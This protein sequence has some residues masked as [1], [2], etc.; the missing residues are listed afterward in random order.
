[1]EEVEVGDDDGEE[2]G[3]GGSSGEKN[4]Y[5]QMAKQFMKSGAR[6]RRASNKRLPE[7]LER[8]VDVKFTDVAGLGKIRLK[9]EEI[10]RD[11]STSWGR[12]E[13][14]RREKE[15]W[16]KRRISERWRRRTRCSQVSRSMVLGSGRIS[17]VILSS[18]LC[19]VIALTSTS[20][21]LLSSSSC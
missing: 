9:L 8:G 2:E 10:V 15:R 5:L 20:R 6:V 4:P 21:S 7:Y 3:E 11:R 19:S 14:G 17:S 12:R 18:L 13:E 16:E 1:M